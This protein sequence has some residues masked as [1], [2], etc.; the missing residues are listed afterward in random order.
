MGKF[1]GSKEGL[2]GAT[3]DGDGFEVKEEDAVY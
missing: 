3:G 1:V 2:Q